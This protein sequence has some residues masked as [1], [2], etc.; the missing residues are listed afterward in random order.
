[1]GLDMFCYG[2]LGDIDLDECL[3][4]IYSY[5]PWGDAQ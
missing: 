1:M 5:N 3:M 2:H 4:A